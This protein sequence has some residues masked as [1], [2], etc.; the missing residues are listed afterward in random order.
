MSVST[1]AMKLIDG[2]RRATYGPAREEFTKVAAVWSAILGVD[3]DPAHVPLCM[4]GLKMVRHAFKPKRMRI[5][6]FP[7]PW[8]PKRHKVSMPEKA[9]V[10]SVGVQQGT[11]HLWALVAD[12]GIYEDRDVLVEFTGTECDPGDLAFV[13]TIQHTNGLVFHVFC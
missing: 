12:D 4:V 6:K 11:L 9:K 8:D 10:L 7:I 5:W 1:E 3:V 13:G 2:D